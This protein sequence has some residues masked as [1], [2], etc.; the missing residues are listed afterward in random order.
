MQAWWD[1]HPGRLEYEL[2]ALRVAGIEFDEPTLNP[3][4]GRAYLDLRFSL[5]GQDLDLRAS[6]PAFY[7]YVRFE[8][9]YLNGELPR[10]MNPFERNLCL[11]GRDTWNWHVDDTLAAFVTE[12]LPVVFEAAGEIDR[13]RAAEIE[14]HQGEPFS[15][16]YPYAT[17]SVILVDSSWNIPSDVDH[18]RLAIGWMTP[19]NTAGPIRGVV[20]QVLD[21][22]GEVIASADPRL[23]QLVREPQTLCPWVRLPEPPRTSNP[24]EIR[25]MALAAMPRGSSHHLIGI[26]YPEEV[27]WREY[28]N[29]WLFASHRSSPTGASS[30]KSETVLVRAGRAGP[31]DLAT[32]SPEATDLQQRTIAAFGL[33]ALGSTSAVTFA[34]AGVG[35]LRL[36]DHDIV[37][38]GSVVRWELGL[39]AAGHSKAEVLASHIALNWPCTTTRPF[40]WRIGDALSPQINE[41]ELM[42][43]ALDGVDLIFDATAEFGIQYLLAT[44]ASERHLPYVAVSVTEGGRGAMILRLHP[45]R[46]EGCWVC[47]RHH[48]ELGT[49]ALPPSAPDGLLQPIGCDEPTY[50]GSPIDL[51]LAAIHAVRGAVD[52]LIDPNGGEWWDVAVGTLRNDSGRL[53]VPSWQVEK[54]SQHKDCR[55][56]GTHRG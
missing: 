4:T 22:H 3:A 1:R 47:H 35:D 49:I 10:H 39:T 45:D 41:L 19:P 34:R 50:T 24:R 25:K 53:I 38:P 44:I 29:S 21:H 11:I 15:A 30:P 36:V 43:A 12:R 33:G 55:N 27:R 20:L 2:E 48:V 28:D 8:V 56:H 23:R 9:Q 54:L 37:E 31:A 7:P 40:V 52:A 5:D 26:L 18:G 16:Y 51:Q 32:R 6:F 14:E 42:D 13:R 17:G 46:T